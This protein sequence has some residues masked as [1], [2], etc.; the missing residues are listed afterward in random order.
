MELKGEVNSSNFGKDKILQSFISGIGIPGAWNDGKNLMLNKEALDLLGYKQEEIDTVKSW[1]NIMFDEQADTI[2]TDVYLPNR[3]MN[4]PDNTEYPLRH[5]DGSFKYVYFSA[6]IQNEEEI[7]I[8]H[9]ID[10]VEVEPEEES[11]EEELASAVIEIDILEKKYAL[12]NKRLK[13]SN[14]ELED[15]AYVASHDLKEPLRKIVAFSARLRE[16]YNNQLD[17]KAQ[18]YIERMENASKRMQALIDDLLRY[19]RVSRGS[20]EKEYLK[21][22]EVFE[23]VE[24]KLELLLERKMAKVVKGELLDFK[25]N[26]NLIVSLFQNLINNAV[27]FQPEGQGPVVNIDSSIDTIR[28]K[29]YVHYTVKDNGIGMEKKYLKKIFNIFERLH[30]KDDYS[31]TGIGLAICHRIVEKH[32]GKISVE[33]AIG[34]GTIFHIYLP[35]T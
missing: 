7:W 29:E 8:M 13:K 30:G 19:S 21:G 14:R 31:G 32:N 25:G 2:Y 35:K 10:K 26:R 18:F 22:K 5:K 3:A 17:E 23:V 11:V 1:F 33:S 12:E 6:S 16:K 20:F 4:F 15:F 24:D 34:Q 28:N 9:P 27:K